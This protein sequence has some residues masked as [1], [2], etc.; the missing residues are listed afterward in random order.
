MND[1]QLLIGLVAIA[2]TIFLGLVAIALTVF[3]G[4]KG[5]PKGVQQELSTIKDAV[6]AIRGT[7]EKTWDL[8][9]RQFGASA[10]TV[11]RELE[12]LGK[13]RITAEPGKDETS[14]LIEVEKP[15]LRE[16]LLVRASNQPEFLNKEKEFFGEQSERSRGVF[17]SPNRTRFYLPSTDPKTCTEFMTFLLK[18]LNS[19]YIESLGE[20]KEFEEPILT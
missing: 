14:Y 20:I 12:N 6:L 18:W 17:L 1:S 15:V 8:V 19:T 2:V 16:G 11:E 13:V 10:G 7:A 5:L 4:L 9:V 3:F